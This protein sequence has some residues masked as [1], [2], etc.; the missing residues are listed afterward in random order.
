MEMGSESKRIMFT[1]GGLELL[2]MLF[3]LD[4]D[5]VICNGLKSIISTSGEL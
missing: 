4:I 1:S 3:E 5:G 2:Q